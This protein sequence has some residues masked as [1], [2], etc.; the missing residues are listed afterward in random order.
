MEDMGATTDEA[1]VSVDNIIEKF[2]E[3]AAAINKKEEK[4]IEVTYEE[5]VLEAQGDFSGLNTAL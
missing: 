1:R 4:K 2:K 5:A 3:L